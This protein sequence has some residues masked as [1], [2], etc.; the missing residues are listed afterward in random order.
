MELKGIFFELIRKYSIDL[1]LPE[2]LWEEIEVAYKSKKRHYHN[3]IHLENLYQQ[4]IVIKPQIEDWDTILFSLFYHDVIYNTL[5]KDNEDK[6]AKLAQK[7]L[8]Q[9][10]YS[11]LKIEKCV[12]QIL[13]TKAH[14]LTT[15]IDTNLFT[16][17]DLSILGADWNFYKNYAAQIRKEYCI[18]PDFMYN[19]GRKKGISPFFRDE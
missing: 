14:T 4:L 7:K 6:S 3:L 17:A 19:S 18:Y 1:E 8:E 9:I 2:K 10:S 16:D 12:Q 5:R 15:D 13:A 11:E